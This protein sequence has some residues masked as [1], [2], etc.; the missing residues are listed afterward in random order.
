MKLLGVTTGRG[1]DGTGAGI[2]SS[3]MEAI[4]R[5]PILYWRYLYSYVNDRSHHPADP[6]RSRIIIEIRS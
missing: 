4:A 5:F 1:S 3:M 2:S 6:G